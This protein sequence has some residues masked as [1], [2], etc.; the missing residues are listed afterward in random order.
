MSNFALGKVIPDAV[1]PRTVAKSLNIP[2]TAPDVV[3]VGVP[4]TEVALRPFPEESVHT[5]VD[6]L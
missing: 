6:A 1:V 2:K 4:R 3:L 5:L